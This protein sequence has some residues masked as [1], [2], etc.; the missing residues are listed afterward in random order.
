MNEAYK[1]FTSHYNIFHF[2][3]YVRINEKNGT[4][5][6]HQDQISVLKFHSRQF[7][8]FMLENVTPLL[9]NNDITAYIL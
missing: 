5:V 8:K 7:G 2:D 6:H 9:P 4:Y 3:R 1:A